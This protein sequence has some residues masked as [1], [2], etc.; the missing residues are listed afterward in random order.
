MMSATE[1]KQTVRQFLACFNTNNVA[2]VLEMMTDDVT[3]WIAG[4]A[5]QLPA[6]GT[7]DKQQATQLLN[8]MVSQLPNGV[9]MTVKNLIAE[10]DQ[11]A[12]EVEGYGELANG[13]VYQQ[14]YHFLLTVRDGKISGINEYLDTQ[15][16][17]AVWFQQ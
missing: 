11:V 9:K 3:W 16:V 5:D 13:R 12:A 15:H 10:N 7:Y 6:A 14:Q 8:N 2:G 17:Y 1:N 4:K